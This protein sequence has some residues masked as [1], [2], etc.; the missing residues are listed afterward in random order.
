MSILQRYI[1]S[2]SIFARKRPSDCEKGFDIVIGN[3][4]YGASLS[5][6]IKDIYKKLYKDVHMRTPDTF[7]YFISNGIRLLRPAGCLSYIVP[8]D[9]GLRV[10]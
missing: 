4:P 9:T 7:N 10:A 5:F 2:F 6:E 8:N 1:A 3:P